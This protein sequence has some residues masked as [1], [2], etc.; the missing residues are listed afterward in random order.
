M[1]RRVFSRGAL[2]F[3]RTNFTRTRAF[4]ESRSLELGCVVSFSMT[5][6]S[7]ASTGRRRHLSDQL[8]IAA[9]GTR[10]SE[11]RPNREPALSTESFAGSMGARP[12][13]KLALRAVASAISADLE[14]FTDV[15]GSVPFRCA[16][17]SDAET[18]RSRGPRQASPKFRFFY[19]VET[20]IMP[21]VPQ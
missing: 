5:A 18:R 4:H 6:S 17:H 2:A 10:L 16:N 14:S 8:T 1:R 20:D 13:L 19:C 7:P 11:S 15:T 12:A 21:A 9:V 3:F